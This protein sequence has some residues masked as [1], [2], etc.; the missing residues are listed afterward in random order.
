MISSLHKQT[1][2]KW[3]QNS[4]AQHYLYTAAHLVLS[5]GLGGGRNIFPVI[6]LQIL[7]PGALTWRR[8]GDQRSPWRPAPDVALI[9]HLG[10]KHPRSLLD[11]AHTHNQA[12]STHPDS[13]THHILYASIIC[14]VVSRYS[15]KW[16]LALWCWLTVIWCSF[17][18]F[19]FFY[20]FCCRKYSHNAQLLIPA[21]FT[22]C[23]S[24]ASQSHPQYWTKTIA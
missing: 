24:M 22:I 20:D 3:Q 14:Q 11:K 15:F 1:K 10:C 23:T 16:F 9:I 7:W 8:H 2:L 5:N 19:F 17:D 18:F 12:H 6:L 4:T 21:N 13:N